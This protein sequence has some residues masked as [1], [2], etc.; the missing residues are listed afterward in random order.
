MRLNTHEVDYSM[1]IARSIHSQSVLSSVFE[2]WSTVDIIAEEFLTV[3]APVLALGTKTI[4]AEERPKL[5]VVSELHPLP[6]MVRRRHG[7]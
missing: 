2:L 5:S 7:P 4:L 6:Q 1:G 3:Q